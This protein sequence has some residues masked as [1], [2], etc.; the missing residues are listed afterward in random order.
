MAHNA[1]VEL[2]WLTNRRLELRR[3][4]VYDTMLGRR[5]LRAGLPASEGLS[6]WTG[7]QHAVQQA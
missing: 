4:V 6:V 1:K 5:V 3:L 7:W 2:G